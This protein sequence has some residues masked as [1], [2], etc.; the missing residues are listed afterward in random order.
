MRRL[1]PARSRVVLAIIAGL[2]DPTGLMSAENEAASPTYTLKYQFVANQFTHLNVVH[3]ATITTEYGEARETTFNESITRKHYRVVSVDADGSAVLEPVIDHVQ[4]KAQF[5]DRE[6]VLFDSNW[7]DDKIPAKFMDIKKS[8]GHPTARFR[9]NHFGRLESVS[10]LQ[11]G[12]QTG[13]VDADSGDNDPS[14]NF[15]VVLPE[16]PVQIGDTWT[17]TFRTKVSINNDIQREVELLRTYRLKSVEGS[18]AV[19]S[20]V[21]SVTDP[22]RKPAIRAQLIQREPSGTIRFDLDRGLVLERESTVDKTVFECF[23]PK[24]SMKAVSRRVEKLVAPEVAS[25]VEPSAN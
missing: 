11:V 23:G 17:D 2:F 1:L 8:V 25:K 4:M 22:I 24:S 10:R 19:I 6:P 13:P 12:S 14:R 7:S 9:V 3:E 15:L 16:K 18:V 21:T 5:G 20:M